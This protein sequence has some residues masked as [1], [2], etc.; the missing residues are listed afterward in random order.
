MKQ[1]DK[2]NTFVSH[3]LLLVSQFFSECI[4]LAIYENSDNL[5]DWLPGTNFLSYFTSPIFT[6][7]MCFYVT[8]YTPI[9][10]TNQDMPCSYKEVL[11]DSNIL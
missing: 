11:S 5:V 10:V 2:I 9:A 1:R 3:I 6:S 8:L 7:E 4:F